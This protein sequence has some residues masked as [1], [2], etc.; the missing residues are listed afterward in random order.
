MLYRDSTRY[1]SNH[2]RRAYRP[3][4][5]PRQ[6]EDALL[7][8]LKLLLVP[9]LAKARLDVNVNTTRGAKAYA[10]KGKGQAHDKDDEQEGTACRIAQNRAGRAEP[11]KRA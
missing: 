9:L 10:G 7:V 11:I 4:A 6:A 1:L 5:W 3:P 8:V 2:A